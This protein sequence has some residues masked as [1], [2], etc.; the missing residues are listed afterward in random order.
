MKSIKLK[1]VNFEIFE[2][3]TASYFDKYMDEVLYLFAQSEANVVVFEDLDRFDDVYIFEK[4]REIE[5][6][7]SVF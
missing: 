6:L 1:D 5:K 3:K 2:E 7:G 4:L